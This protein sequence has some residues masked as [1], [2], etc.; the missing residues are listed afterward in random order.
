M[1]YESSLSASDAAQLLELNALVYA[2]IEEMLRD[3]LSLERA[4][5][6]LLP[7]LAERT[8]AKAVF[9]HSFDEGLTLKTFKTTDHPS[10][11]DYIAKNATEHTL[12]GVF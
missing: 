4:L 3:R 7:Q 9:V 8:G 6:S 10:F 12:G 2:R 5:E 1:K 11:A